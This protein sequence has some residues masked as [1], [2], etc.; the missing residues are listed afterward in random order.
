MTEIKRICG[1]KYII[2]LACLLVL[3]ML[4]IVSDKT[5]D[6]QAI[7]A[8]ND[9]INIAD[10]YQEDTMTCTE[11]AMSAWREYFQTNKVDAHDNSAESVIAKQARDRIMQQAK[12]I[13]NY[14]ETVESKKKTAILYATSGTYKKNSF[15]YNN[16]LKTQYDLSQIVDV[17]LQ[18]SN[19]VWLER[20]YKNNYIH[21]LAL[22]TCIYTV[23]MFFAERKKGLYH[24]VH[25]SQNGRGRLFVKRSFILLIQA[26]I[27]N[28]LLYMEASLILIN[29]YG[30]ANGLNASAASDECFMLTAGNLSR[31]EFAGVIILVS[32]LTCLVLSLVLWGVLLCFS[33]VNI[34]LFFYCFVCVADIAVYKLISIKSAIRILKHLNVYYLFFPNKAIEY[35]NWG[36]FG[37][38]ASLLTTTIILSIFIGCL[39]LI[40]SAYIS[41]KKHFTGKM[42]VIEIV[43]NSAQTFVMRLLVKSSNFLKEIYKILISQGIIWVLL[44]LIFVAGNVTTSHGVI[45]DAKKSYML[46]YYERAE[47]LSYGPELIEIYNEYNDAYEEFLKNFDYSIDN[48]GM[49]L[50]NQKALFNN[51]KENFNYIKRMNEQGI[52]AVVINPYEYTES[53][54]SREWNNQELIAMI[55]VIAAIVISCGFISYEKKSMVQNLML[56]SS[57]R[58]K[59]LAKKMFIQS[60]LC[61]VF[62]CITYGMYYWKLCDIYTYTNITAP[63]KSLPLFE[64]Y[65]INPPIIVYIFIDFMMK[66]MF[67]VGIQLIMSVISIY[68]K[69]AYCFAAGLVIILPQLLY[70]IGF[71]F[72][73]QLSIVKY[74]SFFGCWI[75]GGRTMTVY[76]S[77]SGIIISVGICAVIYIMNVFQHN[78]SGNKNYRKRS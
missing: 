2:L 8:Y 36:Y 39:A 43:V 28:V 64:N 34:G 75:G 31:I 7:Q 13:D 3:N 55:N 65:V 68:V 59:W 14:K 21:L 26:V 9:M 38:I 12:Y 44:V 23:Y 17:K 4:I 1:N 62:S 27:T 16:L 70:M 5:Y 19:G 35:F 56:T 53:I 60:I 33:N 15:E 37:I 78:I 18:L 77:L 42:N 63:L 67:L 6:T 20:L 46:E 30:G 74:I 54:G 29:K 61:L 50:A 49:I 57:K 11:T 25:T 40:I 71:E 48:A 45:Y 41:I 76:W 66:Y 47:G 73:H 69:Y 51:L 24:I 10:N 58:R 22:V 32:V 72:L 52:S